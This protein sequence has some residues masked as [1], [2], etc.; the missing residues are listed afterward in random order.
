MLVCALSLHV[1]SPYL[2]RRADPTTNYDESKVGAYT[3]PDPLIFNN[4][5][6]VR[7]ARDWKRRRAEILELF[8]TNVYGHSPRAPKHISYDVFDIDKAAL[9]GKAVRKQVTIY[10]SG[11]KNGPREDVL[12]YI[13]AGARKPVPMFLTLNF[14]GNQS[15]INDPGIKLPTIW[16]WKTH[17][18]ATGVGR[19][20][21]QG[22][23]NSRS[24]KSW[25]ADTAS[26]PSATRT[27]SRISKADML[28]ASV[29]YFSNPD[30]L[31]L[32]R[33]TGEPS[34]PGPMV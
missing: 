20:A 31:S 7:S 30:R 28:K 21:G 10:F 19:I 32:R 23:A 15:V 12:I 13:P 4:G 8:A 22:H 34:E 14:S 11:N 29:R 6:P 3:L 16:D 33:T 2:G 27:S 5:K 26:P 25:L 18:E 9:G 24:R 1:I 17:V